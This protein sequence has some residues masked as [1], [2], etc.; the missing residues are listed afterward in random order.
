MN[1]TV[2][3]QKSL[4]LQV[5]V[6]GQPLL[7]LVDSGSSACFLDQGKTHLFE[8]RQ[9]LAKPLRVQ[10]LGGEI[11]QS[12][13]YFLDLCWSVS[14]HE[15]CD[16][17]KILPLQSYDGIIGHDWLAKHSLMLTHWAQN[18]IALFNEGQL[19]V[20]HGEGQ[21]STSHTLIELHV[22]KESDDEESRKINP[23]VQHLLDQFAGVIVTP[24]GLPPRRQYDHQR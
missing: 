2:S 4:L 24:T 23:G 19:I 1:P 3:S 6:Q 11:L 8:G 5:V 13:E 17:F 16:A 15:L 12:N 18:W 22:V 21:A 10:V 9:H 7:F 14:R 20:L